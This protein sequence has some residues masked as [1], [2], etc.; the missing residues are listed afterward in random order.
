MMKKNVKKMR[1]MVQVR[2]MKMKKSLSDLPLK[3]R[4]IFQ[5]KRVPAVTLWF[6]QKDLTSVMIQSVLDI[7]VSLLHIV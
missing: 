2:L 6:F 5:E 4:I 3:M 1:K 7:D